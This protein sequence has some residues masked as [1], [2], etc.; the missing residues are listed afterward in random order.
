MVIGILYINVFRVVL[1]QRNQRQLRD[2]I[3]TGVEDGNAGFVCKLI[4]LQT[5]MKLILACNTTTSTSV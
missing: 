3:G 5:T 1:I 4:N 2:E